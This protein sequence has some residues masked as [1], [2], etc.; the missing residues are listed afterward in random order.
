MGAPGALSGPNGGGR[1][2]GAKVLGGLYRPSEVVVEGGAQ[3]GLSARYG[4]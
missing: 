2:Q 3:G 1:G 4:G